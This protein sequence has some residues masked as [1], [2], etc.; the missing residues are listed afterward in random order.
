MGGRHAGTGGRNAPERVDGM[1]ESFPKSVGDAGQSPLTAG[2]RKGRVSFLRRFTLTSASGCFLDD[3]SLGRSSSARTV[4]GQTRNRST[5]NRNR[6]RDR[7]RRLPQPF[8]NPEKSSPVPPRLRG[9]KI[10]VR[11]RR[12]V[13][14]TA[15]QVSSRRQLETHPFS[16]GNASLVIIGFRERARTLPTPQ[17]CSCRRS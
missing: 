12:L 2:M 8:P 10:R 7:N 11:S 6:N 15:G 1:P 17:A 14:S 4:A 16:R 5:R 9:I 13:G 3:S